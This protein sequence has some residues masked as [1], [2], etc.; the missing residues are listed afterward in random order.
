MLPKRISAVTP[1][2]DSTPA[3]TD[4]A[5]LATWPYKAIR[6]PSPRPYGE[7]SPRLLQHCQVLE[8]IQKSP[9]LVQRIEL[10][11]RLDQ[12][13]GFECTPPAIRPPLARKERATS[14]HPDL[15]RMVGQDFSRLETMGSSQASKVT[16]ETSD[17]ARKCKNH[18]NAANG[19][20]NDSVSAQFHPLSRAQ[21]P[22]HVRV[23]DL[24]DYLRH[25]YCGTRR[26]WTE[27]H[28]ALSITTSLY[29]QALPPKPENTSRRHHLH[30][31]VF[32]SAYVRRKLRPLSGKY[33]FH[34]QLW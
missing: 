5:I 1:A 18:K 12:T 2:T 13:H 34:L 10:P 15:T 27:D 33:P 7:V 25:Q 23:L 9:S 29:I 17:Q 4:S 32:D 20:E 8:R 21:C 14:L 16:V 19:S 28:A 22:T 3:L 11:P 6:I 31:A 24:E 26:P 30:L